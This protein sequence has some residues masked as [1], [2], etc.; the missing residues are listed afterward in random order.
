MYTVPVQVKSSQVKS[1]Y[2]VFIHNRVSF[3][4]PG[5]SHHVISLLVPIDVQFIVIL[6]SFQ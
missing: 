2:K 5:S 1:S 4:V 6:R 3:V